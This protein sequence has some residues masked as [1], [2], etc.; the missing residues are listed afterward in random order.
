MGADKAV[1]QYYNILIS[2]KYIKGTYNNKR[3]ITI[4]IKII[5]NYKL[6]NRIIIVITNNTSNNSSIA[7]VLRKESELR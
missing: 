2:F 4:T 1:D 3:L 6:E 7:A 5:D